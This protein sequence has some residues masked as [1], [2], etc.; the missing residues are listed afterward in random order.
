MESISQTI[1]GNFVRFKPLDT[2]HC[3]A[4]AVRLVSSIETSLQMATRKQ[5]GNCHTP[6]TI[7]MTLN[8][9]GQNF[10]WQLRLTMTT[11]TT[12]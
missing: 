10:F 7:T 2:T 5:H 6:M 3:T 8:Y 11:F 9:D 1:S 4:N 12:R